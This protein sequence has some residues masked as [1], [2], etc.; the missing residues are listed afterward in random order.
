[1]LVGW[2]VRQ[3]KRLATAHLLHVDVQ[4]SLSGTIRSV[5]EEFPVERKG[6]VGRQPRIR[7]EAG[8]SERGGGDGVWRAREPPHDSRAR[9]CD[10]R[11]HCDD[12]PSLPPPR[13]DRRHSYSPPGFRI[14][15]QA[16]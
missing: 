11:Q 13:I 15:L 5:G 9:R 3:P 8:E 4:V 12:P 16:L 10:N 6:R 1:M 14:A 2:I 7:G